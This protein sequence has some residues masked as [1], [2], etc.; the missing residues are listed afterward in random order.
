MQRALLAAAFV[1]LGVPALASD[2]GSV[3]SKLEQAGRELRTMQARFVET[4]TLVLLDEH[5]SSSGEVM[6]R[7]PGKLRWD[8]QEPQPSAMLIT[9]GHFSRYFPRTKQ[10]FRGKAGGESDLLVGFGPGAADLAEKYAVTLVGGEAVSNRPAHVLDLVPLKQGGLFAEIRM[11]VDAERFFPVQ[12]RLM[13]PTGD[14]TTIRFEDV[15]I[16][17]GLPGDAFELKLPSDVVVVK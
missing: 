3:L 11:W 13:E 14:Y 6:L 17:A 5:E 10:V 12:T 16:N 8:Y 15:R 1:A 9:D 4:R 7:V 2:A